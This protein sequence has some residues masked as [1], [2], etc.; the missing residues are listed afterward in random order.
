MLSTPPAFRR[1]NCSALGVA[2][3]ATPQKL[4]GHG[5][6]ASARGR[7]QRRRARDRDRRQSTRDS[8]LQAP[9]ASAARASS[10]FGESGAA[11]AAPLATL[12]IITTPTEIAASARIAIRIGTSGEEP[13]SSDE[14]AVSTWRSLAACCT[15]GLGGRVALPLSGLP[16]P[17]PPPLPVRRRAP[18]FLRRFRFRRLSPDSAPNPLRRSCRAAVPA[19]FFEV[20]AIVFVLWWAAAVAFRFGT[21]GVLH[22]SSSVDPPEQAPESKPMP[23]EQALTKARE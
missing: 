17:V 10:A 1:W 12:A 3:G 8:P 16:C 2:C 14:E 6:G 13:P 22:H 19:P 5:A 11:G 7:G 18:T 21:V 15:S 4:R 20:L 9:A 23:A